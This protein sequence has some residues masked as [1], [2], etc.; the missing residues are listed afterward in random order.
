MK[1]T[2]VLQIKNIW[3]EWMDHTAFKELEPA[4]RH[5]D[6]FDKTKV[7]VLKRILTEEVV[8]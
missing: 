5:S 2:Y 6:D 8:Y 4:I 1:T 3:G 7:R